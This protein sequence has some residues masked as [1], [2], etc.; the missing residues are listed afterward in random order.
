MNKKLIIFCVIALFSGIISV[1]ISIFL[2]QVGPYFLEQEIKRNAILDMNSIA[3]K[4]WLNS[5]IK[6]FIKF[7]F[8]DVKNPHDVLNGK[9][10]ILN[11]IGPFMYRQ[12]IDKT[13]LQFIDT[14]TISYNTKITLK[15]EPDLSFGNESVIINF[16]NIPAV[17]LVDEM[18]RIKVNHSFVEVNKWLS[19]TN[20]K[21]FV[22]KSI[23][24][25][26]KG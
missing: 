8:F 24:N 22:K 15:F 10:P 5:T 23:Q 20:T 9:K 1:I 6:S 13:N 2:H 18:S 16:L 21:L 14:N 4:P 26:I 25:L 12:I 17:A 3:Y 7:Y 11:E 19:F